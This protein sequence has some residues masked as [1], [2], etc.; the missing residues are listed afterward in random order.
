MLSSAD[1]RSKREILNWTQ[2]DLANES[3]VSIAT[4]KRLE[5]GVH[6]LGKLLNDVIANTMENAILKAFPVYQV[7]VACLEFGNFCP[8]LQTSWEDEKPWND[9]ELWKN[10]DYYSASAADSNELALAG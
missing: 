10:K 5:S 1:V 9:G 8:S 3:G 4:I 7:T 6:V 2:E